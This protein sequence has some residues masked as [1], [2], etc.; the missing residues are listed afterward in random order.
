MIGAVPGAG[1]KRRGKRKKSTKK[2]RKKI[3]RITQPPNETKQ[4]RKC[5]SYLTAAAT[6]PAWIAVSTTSTA[7]PWART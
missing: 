1:G 4:N 3:K 7:K 2:K 6:V 5:F